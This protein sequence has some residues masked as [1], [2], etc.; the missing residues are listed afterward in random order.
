MW[1]ASATKSRNIPK[2]PQG[3]SNGAETD[4]AEG[5]KA[6]PDSAV[7]AEASEGPCVTKRP[8]KSHK[9]TTRESET[10]PGPVK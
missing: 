4:T 5:K 1:V 9:I 8:K 10:G 7:T 3:E 6:A 2:R